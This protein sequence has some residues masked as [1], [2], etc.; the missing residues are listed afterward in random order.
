MKALDIEAVQAFVL[1]A[2]LVSFTRAAEAMDSTQS[3]VS[4]KIKRLEDGLGRRLFERTP[5]RVRLTA[6]GELFLER[7]RTLIAAHSNALDAFAAERRRL[8]VGISDHAVGAELPLLLQRVKRADP[9][10]LLEM[11]VGSSRDLLAAFDDGALDAAVVMGHDAGRRG[12][13]VLLAEAFGWMA[14]R[15]FT[16]R[17]G[18]PIPLAAQSDYCGMRSM[19]VAALDNAGIPWTEVF[20]GGGVGTIAAAVSAGIAVAVLGRRVAPR[21]SIDLGPSLGLPALP[22]RDLVLY[23]SLSDP[24]ARQSLKTLAA[25][26]RSTAG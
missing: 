10:L 17:P 22:P 15:D 23:A 5:R 2:D 20:V 26:I 25:A 24:V 4:L 11:R 1:V 13:E 6:A 18:D 3:A 16:H 9:N 8:V 7:A 21:D 14:A 12:G 19:G